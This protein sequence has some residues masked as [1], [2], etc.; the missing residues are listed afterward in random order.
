MGRVLG[1]RRLSHD[2]DASTSIERQGESIEHWAMAHGHTVVAMTQDTDVSGSVAPHDRDDLG[3]W[4]TDRAR[5]AQWDILCVAK[6]DRLTRSVRH[7]DDLRIWADEHGKTIASVAESLDLSTSTGRMFANLLAMFAQFERER[8]SER[9]ADASRKLYSRGGYNGGS[10]LPWGY[11][12]IRQNGR[13]ELELDP[14]EVAD[15]NEIVDDVLAGKAVTAVARAHGI[16]PTTLLR[17]LRSPVLKGFVIY[18]DDIVRDA[19]G[20]PVLRDPVIPAATWSRLQAKLSANSAGAG[21][22]HNGNWLLHVVYCDACKRPMYLTK[23]R[24]SRG[25]RY[26]YYRHEREVCRIRVNGDSL[27]A[28]VHDLVMLAFRGQYVPEVIE[29]AAEDHT[30]ELARIDEAIADWEARAVAGDAAASVMRILDG[31][32]A[33]R[34]ALLSQEL[35]T[36]ARQEVVMTDELLTDRWTSLTTDDDRGMLLR[37][38]NVR[39]MASKAGPARTRIRLQQGSRNWADVAREW[40]DADVE[41]FEAGSETA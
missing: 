30:A 34:T 33:K 35:K 31:L 2:T 5:L 12:T 17:R 22:P 14:D 4:L 36:E 10:S 13:L 8:M 9:R 41:Q 39:I 6:L 18:D 37:L 1:G 16:N 29:V 20:L 27:E 38:L 7:F 11:R 40:T 26:R 25:R 24:N 19:D 15:I 28:Q 23:T 32:H 21:V 3:P